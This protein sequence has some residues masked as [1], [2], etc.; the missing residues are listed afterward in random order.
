[1]SEEQK[2]VGVPVN[3]VT[4][5]LEHTLI[6]L[7]SDMPSRAQVAAL[8]AECI[9]PT[10]DTTLFSLAFY[11]M[12]RVYDLSFT[13]GFHILKLSNSS[14]LIFN[15]QFRKTLGDSSEAVVVLAD[16]DCPAVC[17]FRAVTAC[18]STAQRMG[19]NLTAGSIFIVVTAGGGQGNLPFPAAGITA[20]LKA[21]LRMA[22]LPSHFTTHSFRFG[23]TLS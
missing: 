18:I 20:A 22:G 23:G 3:R 17:P 10:R 13:L 11:S 19:W 4:P 6:D 14:D 12:G 1:M 8:L 15:F 16:R 21:Y 5:K 9:S 7:L 2:K